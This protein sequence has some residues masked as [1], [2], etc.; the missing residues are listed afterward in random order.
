MKHFRQRTFHH[1][2]L[3][4]LQKS[5]RNRNSR[6]S[7]PVPHPP[8]GSR[9]HRCR[10]LSHH[11]PT[12]RYPGALFPQYRSHP[13]H[14][15][16]TSFRPPLLSG[17]KTYSYLVLPVFHPCQNKARVPNYHRRKGHFQSPSSSLFHQT[18]H[19][20]PGLAVSHQSVDNL[21]H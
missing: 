15:R 6:Q 5:R 1:T 2:H 14:T 13:V 4:L 7:E 16:S 10:N 8:E 21:S 17:S 20:S 18:C 3:Y 11:H 12:S 19:N 9:L